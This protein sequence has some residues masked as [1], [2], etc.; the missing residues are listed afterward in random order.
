MPKFF[1]KN[2][3]LEN[4]KITILGEDVKHISNVLRMKAND[5]IQVCNTDTQINYNVQLKSFEKDKVIGIITETIAS[6]AESNINL[7]IFQ[8]IPKSDKMELI[9]QKSTE[10]GVKE[11]IPVD[12][13]RC[14]SKISGKDEA[15]KIDRWQKI[16]EVAA[17]QSGRDMIPNVGNVMTVKQVC[18]TVCELDMLI[19][20]YERAEGYSFKDAVE[21]LKAENKENVSIGIVIG[22]EGGFESSEIELL[23]ESGAK[24]VTLGKR[25]L[26]TETVALAM[27][28][29]IMYELGGSI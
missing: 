1:V 26:R 13:E 19:V 9:I 17:K 25:I 14:V 2:D 16:A 6:E 11:F 4:D 5:V 22:P 21:E 12:M 10:L 20:P 23:K 15:K 7:K 8:G 27:S 29:V 3:Q 24:I 28:S 18:S